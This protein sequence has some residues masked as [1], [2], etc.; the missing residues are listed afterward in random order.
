MQKLDYSP[1]KIIAVLLA[2]QSLA[3]ASLIMVVT[4]ASIELVALA[5]G[6]KQWT[7]VPGTTMLIGEALIAYPASRLM[8]AIGRR[9]GLSLGHV[10]GIIGA[11]VTAVGVFTSSILLF[12]LGILVL[13]FARG[14][15]DLGRYAA[16]DANP[17]DRRARA[18]S[19]V[20]L[21]G[22]VG[23]IAGPTLI[24]VAQWLAT[25][26]R[27]PEA[28][29]AWLLMSVFFFL[30]IGILMLFLYPDPR[31][32]ARQITAE[33]TLE[34]VIAQPARTWGALAREP[35]I[36]LAVGGLVFSQ[37]AMVTVMTITP[38]EMRGHDHTLS[39]VSWVIMAHTLGMFGFSFVTGWLTDRIG[40]TLVILIGGIISTIACVIA[41]FSSAVPW[42]AIS[43]FLL[44]LG[45]NLSFVASSTLLD[46]TLLHQEKGRGRGAADALVK[47]SSG[48]GGLSSGILFAATSYTV[49][50]WLTILIAIMPIGLA[51][52]ALARRKHA[53]SNAP[54]R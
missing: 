30:A 47:I 8:E 40:R 20:V 49:T 37:L 21:G 28:V 18:I 36:Q 29:G 13:G 31:E 38:V 45:W 35:G 52:I 6:N 44:G 51:L 42:L 39:S 34:H 54:A 41:P 46:E 25:A 5:G 32:I 24:N 23:S 14:T 33:H 12:L 9:L 4:V 26:V 2:S 10:L 50:S 19:L 15:L 16:A 1:N 53:V 7:G 11:S 43:L 48:V 27:L 22:T 3:S 17:P